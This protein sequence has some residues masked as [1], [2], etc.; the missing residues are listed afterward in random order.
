MKRILLTTTALTV[1][2]GAAAAD[3][4]AGV[5]FS[6]DAELKY[7]AGD[8]INAAVDADGGNDVFSWGLDL[9]I[10]ATAELDNGV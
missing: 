5:S 10:G 1:L 3:G 2:A 8:L 6:G 7:V 4:H 9:N